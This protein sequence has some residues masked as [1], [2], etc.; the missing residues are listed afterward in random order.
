M[1]IE[2]ETDQ[3]IEVESNAQG[4]VMQHSKINH[5]IGVM[6]GKGGVGKSFITSTLASSLAREGYRVG[7]LDA[8]YTGPSIAM[9]FGLHGPVSTGQY[10][11]IPL[12]SL[13]GVKVISMNLLFASENTPVIWKEQLVAKVIEELW[14]EVEWGELD[15]LLMD[16]PPATS[17]V[18][19]SIIQSLPLSGLI[20][21]TTPQMLATK[22]NSKAISTVKK[23]G[24]PIV[25]IVENMAFMI[26]LDSRKRQ[27]VFGQCNGQSVAN[28]AEAPILAQIPLDPMISKY[29]DLGNVEDIFLA[30]ESD[31]MDT[32]FE[33][34][35]NLK[36][37]VSTTQSEN[38]ENEPIIVGGQNHSQSSF[39]DIVMK[40][41]QAKENMGVLDQPDA[42]GYFLG[43]C[44]DRMQIDLRLSDG[45][46]QEAK[47]LADG[48][49]AT[50][51]CGSMITKMIRSKTLED[52]NLITQEELLAALHGLP[53]DHTHCAELA[54]LTLRE[55]IIDAIEG[56]GA[57]KK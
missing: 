55:A 45:K 30:E 22:I 5:I 7:I 49:G 34:I 32:F 37:R 28:L 20:I 12:V 29:C 8:D 40:L 18:T 17:E 21:V 54:V 36:N 56:H 41:I 24:T 10:S 39:S 25:G 47:F 16:L 51:A 52:A 50:I 15:Y 43:S 46:I 27:Y 53:E 13:S 33:S 11:F 26:D 14:K 9:L 1:N 44:G 35:E 6:S 38:Q 2:N 31:M 42:Q 48:C 23:I 57:I 3:T 4:H 19:V